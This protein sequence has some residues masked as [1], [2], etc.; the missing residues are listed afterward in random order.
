M[1]TPSPWQ[2]WMRTSQMMMTAPVVMAQRTARMM[3]AGHS[4]SAR[5]QR[6]LRRMSEEKTEAFQESM[7]A[8]TTSLVRANTAL[9]TRMV[10]A[11][12]K[13]GSVS[14]TAMMEH[15]SRAMAGAA[16]A[17]IGPVHRRVMANER[18]LRRPR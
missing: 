17:G 18:R 16:G 8:M 3:A 9:A 15:A 13:G 10:Q 7:V 5:D 14:P 4:P 6:E 2:A 12:M 11:S 1:S